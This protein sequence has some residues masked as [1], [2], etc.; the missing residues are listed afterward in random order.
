MPNILLG[1]RPLAGLPHV[2]F[3]CS[4]DSALRQEG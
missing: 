3:L 4:M 2:L 1:G